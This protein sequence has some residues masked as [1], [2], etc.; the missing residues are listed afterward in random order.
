MSAKLPLGSV[1]TLGRTVVTTALGTVRHPLRTAGQAVHTAGH[2]V[3]T[4]RTLIDI[5]HREP[6]RPTPPPTDT[7]RPAPAAKASGAK[8]PAAKASGAKAPATKASGAKAPA[9]KASAKK[10]P[11]KKA[12]AKK[13]TPVPPPV[14]D[15]VAA[16]EEAVQREMAAQ[17]A[18]PE[19]TTEPSAPAAKAD[20]DEVGRDA[21]EVR[22]AEERE[23]TTP[24]GTTGADV[25]RN[26][27]TAETD[28]QQ[29]GTEPLMDPSTT[30]AVKKETERAARAA[31]P[32]K[33]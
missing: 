23:V 26:P 11:A 33:E 32:E 18:P 19:V 13:G 29:P 24:V 21:A 16:A 10:S 20:A 7:G 28:L 6:V 8:A 25:A 31:D 9:K 14:P 17:P 5:G 22:A 2:A 15:P 27:D 12:A 1:M 30:K 3:H 4:A